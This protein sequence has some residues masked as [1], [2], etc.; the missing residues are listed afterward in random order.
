MSAYLNKVT[1]G[2]SLLKNRVK[3]WCYFSGIFRVFF[4]FFC[5]KL[6][7]PQITLQMKQK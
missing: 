3:L 1:Q 2:N 7:F 5:V 6:E 4:F